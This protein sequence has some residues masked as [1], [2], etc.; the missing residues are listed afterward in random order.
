MC[1]DL[2]LSGY[3]PKDPEKFVFVTHHVLC[4]YFWAEGLRYDWGM[5]YAVSLVANEL[6]GVFMVIR[7]MLSQANLKSSILYVVN[8]TIFTVLYIILRVSFAPAII[9]S[10]YVYPPA[11]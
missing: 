4:I 5:R 10:T 9:F 11:N 8:G 1:V 2:L 6:T 3:W 7:W